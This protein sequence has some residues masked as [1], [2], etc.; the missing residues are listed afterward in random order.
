M[1]KSLIFKALAIVLAIVLLQLADTSESKAWGGDCGSGGSH[2][3]VCYGD[4]LYSIGRQFNVSPNCIARAN[5]LWDPNYIY[6]GQVLYIPQNC[7]PYPWPSHHH[8]GWDNSN[9]GGW[10][11]SNY[12]C[13][14]GDDCYQ[15]S[16]WQGCGNDC[17]WQGSGYDY[18]GYYYDGY[19]QR[20][21]YT[22]GY[23]NNC[24]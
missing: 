22:C 10:D 23:Y 24:Y 4:T 7:P 3:V 19:N 20:Y 17:N 21:S 16:R 11:N 14:G 2:Y 5:R 13:W 9:Y 8:G 1:K 6:A 18:T 12:G 15:R